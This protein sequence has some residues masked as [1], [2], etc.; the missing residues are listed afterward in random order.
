VAVGRAN[1]LVGY[2]AS[3]VSASFFYVVWLVVQDRTPDKHVGVLFDIGL[4][5]FFLLFEGLGAA[6]VLIAFPWYLAIVGA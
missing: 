3:V 6:F 4:A 1:R 2:L 5:V